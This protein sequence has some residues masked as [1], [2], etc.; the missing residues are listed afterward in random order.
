MEERQID[1]KDFIGEHHTNTAIEDYEERLNIIIHKLKFISVEHRPKVAVFEFTGSF[2]QNE[3]SYIQQA[4]LLAGGI[5][6]N[7]LESYWPSNLETPQSPDILLL[8]AKEPHNIVLSEAPGFI[9]QNFNAESPL[10]KNGQ[11]YIIYHANFAEESGKT[12]ADDVEILAEILH[13]GYFI[14]GRNEDAWMQFNIH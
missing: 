5:P 8:I 2:Q 9:L 7:Q 14:F 12:P 13:P 3:R 11:F 4:I 1:L 10:V 6:F